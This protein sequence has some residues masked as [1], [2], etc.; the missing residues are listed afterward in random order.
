MKTSVHLLRRST[1]ARKV[2]DVLNRLEA[3]KVLLCRT[4]SL[5]APSGEKA[6][7][8]LKRSRAPE[9][10]DFERHSA[11]KRG[12]QIFCLVDARFPK[13]RHLIDVVQKY[14]AKPGSTDR[15]T[16]RVITESVREWSQQ[17]EWSESSINCFNAVILLIQPE[18]AAVL[19]LGKAQTRYSANRLRVRNIVSLGRVQDFLQAR[20]KSYLEEQTMTE[21][22]SKD[23]DW[24]WQ[25]GDYKIECHIAH[26]GL[27]NVMRFVLV[28]SDI[29]L[30]SDVDT[31]TRAALEVRGGTASACEAL[32]KGFMRIE[33]PLRGS[34]AVL[35]V[36]PQELDTPD[37]SDAPDIATQS[38]KVLQNLT[39]VSLGG[40]GLGKLAGIV[41]VIG[42]L[43]AISYGVWSA[44]VHQEHPKNAGQDSTYWKTNSKQAD[45]VR[46]VLRLKNDSS[47]NATD[48]MGDISDAKDTNSSI[49]L[50]SGEKTI[51]AIE[52][53][54]RTV[55]PMLLK[56][57]RPMTQTDIASHVKVS[58]TGPRKVSKYRLEL[59][60]TKHNLPS[61]TS[62]V[63]VIID[64]TLTEGKY[65]VRLTLD[66][67]ETT[68]AIVQLQVI[69]SKVLS[70]YLKNTDILPGTLYFG[71]QII[72]SNKFL[73]R[74]HNQI[75]KNY[76][77]GSIEGLVAD[78]SLD[79]RLYYQGGDSSDIQR[80][81]FDMNVI[82]GIQRGLFLP[83]STASVHFEL[84]WQNPNGTELTLYN[85]ERTVYQKPPEIVDNEPSIQWIYRPRASEARRK[86]YLP[87]DIEVTLTKG[88]SIDYEVPLDVKTNGEELVVARKEHLTVP[89]KPIIQQP[90]IYADPAKFINTTV[91][92]T[93]FLAIYNEDNERVLPNTIEQYQK[94]PIRIVPLLSTFE[95][96]RYTCKFLILNLPP[97]PKQETWRL[98]G[99]LFVDTG[100]YI[101]NP[102][103]GYH[104]FTGTDYFR[105]PIVIFYQ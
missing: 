16:L 13:A 30:P 62:R 70:N 20:I 84:N 71:K 18:G 23:E 24:S 7:F 88:V 50:P 100:A 86:G 5:D 89:T 10:T 59:D 73:L 87:N 65:S 40:I 78:M 85:V 34:I 69:P 4:A 60:T 45:T 51:L 15:E 90:D 36:I 97:K 91:P 79:Y 68:I 48:I 96:G 77:G 83:A 22:V 25:A 102:F 1:L 81:R 76:F 92:I 95:N 52:K 57:K 61:E 47:H 17:Q 38:A 46:Q 93:S 27:Q 94:D 6:R 101:T 104:S 105:L 32:R 72:I 26:R 63:K 35:D 28:A 3:P 64:Q 33:E 74:L 75:E 80:F 9:A 66:A 43:G 55:V 42:I 103:N 44:L 21:D 39:K 14:G 8:F 29:W 67:K 53:T 49:Q 82:K 56:T 31:L 11:L 37:G 58:I 2:F 19:T 12:G 99:E 98:A 54:A 41:A